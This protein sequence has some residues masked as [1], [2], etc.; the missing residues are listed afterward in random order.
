MME[1]KG[2]TQHFTFA[3]HCYSHHICYHL[4]PSYQLLRPEVPH[5]RRAVMDKAKVK[6]EEIRRVWEDKDGK[7]S[8]DD[9]VSALNSK[10]E[11]ID[12]QDAKQ[13][14]KITQLDY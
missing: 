8:G 12:I 4:A 9:L 1:L 11:D 2:G 10:D 6:W 7:N 14:S 13:F 5:D 3:N